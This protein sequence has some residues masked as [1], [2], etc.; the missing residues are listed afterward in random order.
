M[1]G[2]RGTATPRW[3]TCRPT[4]AA[5]GVGW[6]PRRRRRAVESPTARSARWASAAVAPVVSTSSHTTT[7][8]VAPR[9]RA[10]ARP[11]GGCGRPGQVEGA[12]GRVEPGLVRQTRAGPE[13]RDAG[14]RGAPRREPGGGGPHEVRRSGRDRAAGPNPVA[15]APARAGDPRSSRR[16]RG[17]R[18]PS[19]P[20]APAARPAAGPGRGVG[21]PC[22]RGP[23]PG[24]CRRTPWPPTGRVSPGGRGVG[25][26]GAGCGSSAAAQA[27]HSSRPGRPHPTQVLPRSRSRAASSTAGSRPAAR[28][29]GNR[30]PAPPVDHPRRS[31]GGVRR[32][33][34]DARARPARC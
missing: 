19:R 17:R 32:S 18:G 14:S 33:R 10:G 31:G 6:P 34:A 27:V 8:T 28:H 23:S 30:D 15:T 16:R 29:G 11:A 26:A 7:C 12:G 2:D 5:H 9:E 13:Q 4:P 21:A 22:A 3:L 24:R 20:R 25:Q 1:T